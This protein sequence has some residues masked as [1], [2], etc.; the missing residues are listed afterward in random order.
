VWPQCGQV[1][2][3]RSIKLLSYVC[4]AAFFSKRHLF[5]AFLEPLAAPGVLLADTARTGNA[6]AVVRGFQ[7]LAA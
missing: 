1:I 6:L 7:V 3:E 5:A 2:S 4:L